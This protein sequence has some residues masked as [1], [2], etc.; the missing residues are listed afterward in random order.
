M[1]GEFILIRPNGNIFIGNEK[2]SK[3]KGLIYKFSKLE[4]ISKNSEKIE[5]TEFSY[6]NEVINGKG[7]EFDQDKNYIY[8][9]SFLNS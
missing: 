3:L 4:E 8:N 5:K 2:N 1:I 6:K 7:V 9:G